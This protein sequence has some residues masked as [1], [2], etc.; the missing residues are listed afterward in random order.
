MDLPNSESNLLND[1]N[2]QSSVGA[3]D[4]ALYSRQLYVL[5]H[6]A[7]QKMSSSDVLIIGLGGLGVEIGNYL[8]ILS[9]PIIIIFISKKC[10]SGWS[11]V[12]YTVG[13]SA[14]CYF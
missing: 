10:Y 1:T 9:H 4:E 11:Q 12:C 5:G 3:I 6:E 2:I 7:M 13:Q 14:S 8:Q